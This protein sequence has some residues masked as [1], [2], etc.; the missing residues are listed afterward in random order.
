MLFDCIAYRASMVFIEH[1]GSKNT[2]VCV[3]HYICIVDIPSI[4][5]S[6]ALFLIQTNWAA[7]WSH[8]IRRQKGRDKRKSATEEA[9]I[10]NIS[11]F[12]IAFWNP[13][14]LPFSAQFGTFGVIFVYPMCRQWWN[15]YECLHISF[16]G[17]G[18]EINRKTNERW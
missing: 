7:K 8:L 16:K 13:K 18:D 9:T 2:Y 14:N 15:I 10:T 5:C 4:E 17:E 6:D 11:L 3:I 1:T 12:A